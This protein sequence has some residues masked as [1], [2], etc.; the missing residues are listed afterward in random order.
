MRLDARTIGV[1]PAVELEVQ[2]AKLRRRVRTS[3]RAVI[4]EAGFDRS[5]AVYIRVEP[6]LL[7]QK[8]AEEVADGPILRV[9]IKTSTPSLEYGDSLCIRA[10]FLMRRKFSSIL[11]RGLPPSSSLPKASSGQLEDSK[12]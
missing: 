8:S 4:S 10:R 2:F 3:E 5:A 11:A 9:H 12:F 7:P 6:L 1:H